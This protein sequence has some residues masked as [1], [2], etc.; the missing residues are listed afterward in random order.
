[1]EK[2]LL[3]IQKDTVL[4]FNIYGFLS[5]TS[6]DSRRRSWMIDKH[7]N[8][9]SKEPSVDN[10]KKHVQEAMSIISRTAYFSSS[11]LSLSFFYDNQ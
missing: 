11:A 1:M 2:S 7:K 4:F 9:T 3:S 5:L 8:K 6:V 10:N